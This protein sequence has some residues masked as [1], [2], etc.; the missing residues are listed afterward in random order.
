MGVRGGMD[1]SRGRRVMQSSQPYGNQSY[2]GQ[3]CHMSYAFCCSAVMLL[4]T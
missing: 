2:G 1:G 3:V 4:T